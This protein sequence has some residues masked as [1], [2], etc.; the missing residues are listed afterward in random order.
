M[1]R[2]FG[3]QSSLD[4]ALDCHVAFFANFPLIKLLTYWN[5]CVIRF[6]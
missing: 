3:V 5:E 1:A 4:I 6:N 2:N